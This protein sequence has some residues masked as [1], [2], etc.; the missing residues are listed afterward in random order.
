M[1]DA[2]RICHDVGGPSPV[3][4]E[5][6]DFVLG[7]DDRTPWSATVTRRDGTAI[8]CLIDPI[9]GG[10]TMIRFRTGLPEAQPS[11]ELGDIAAG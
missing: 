8:L 5:L 11:A 1:V 9:A 10:A 2:M 4:G 6:R 7:R 3:W